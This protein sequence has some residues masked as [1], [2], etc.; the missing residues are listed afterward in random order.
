LSPNPSDIRISLYNPAGAPP[1]VQS[2][3]VEIRKGNFKDPSS[4]LH[5][6]EGTEKLLLISHPTI[7]HKE[8]VDA[9]K[10]AIDAAKQVGVKHL[11]YTSLG[12]S[13]DSVTNVMKA[14]M[15]TEAY[16]K[17]SGMDYTIIREGLYTES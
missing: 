2:S 16:L 11:Y 15:D 17:E 7:A 3:G 9:H 12:F 5:A 10:N 6:F 8:R 4:L 1:V 14:H 13:G